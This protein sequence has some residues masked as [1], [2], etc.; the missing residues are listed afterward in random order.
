MESLTY[1]KKELYRVMEHK[2]SEARP[3]DNRSARRVDSDTE[4]CH[5][6]LH[7]YHQERN[8]HPIKTLFISNYQR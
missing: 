7:R 8:A 3:A 4:H 2:Q 5:A 1:K 6:E